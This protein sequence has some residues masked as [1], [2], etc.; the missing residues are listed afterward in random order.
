[1]FKRL[2]FTSIKNRHNLLIQYYT[3]ALLDVITGLEKVRCKGRVIPLLI[4]SLFWRTCGPDQDLVM[5]GSILPMCDW[6]NSP[7]TPPS[8]IKYPVCT[9]HESSRNL[10]GWHQRA[11]CRF[12]WTRSTKFSKKEKY[13]FKC[14]YLR[15]NGFTVLRFSFWKWV[16]LSCQTQFHCHTWFH[17]SRALR[18]DMIAPLLL[19]SSCMTIWSDINS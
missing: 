11:H 10:A 1:M 9:W 8:G 6:K 2:I 13:A 18:A 16:K 15:I 5:M 3:W 19:P 17:H 7:S 12:V 14:I 4:I